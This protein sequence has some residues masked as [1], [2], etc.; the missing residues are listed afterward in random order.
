M[1]Q[2]TGVILKLQLKYQFKLVIQTLS[3]Q[4]MINHMQLQCVLDQKVGLRRSNDAVYNTE[5][6]IN[7]YFQCVNHILSFEWP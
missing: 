4:N 3:E 5:N 6:R 2:N 1:V 7:I